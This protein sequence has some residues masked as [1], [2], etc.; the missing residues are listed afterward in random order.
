[1]HK[2]TVTP[3]QSE[4]NGCPVGQVRYSADDAEGLA[5]ILVDFGVTPTPLPELPV[6]IEANGRKLKLYGD[7]R[8]DPID[9]FQQVD[10]YIIC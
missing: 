5:E 9:G 10:G 4:I 7:P 2:W 3:E 8:P 1:M 6:E